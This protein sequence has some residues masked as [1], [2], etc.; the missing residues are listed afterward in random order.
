[1]NSI[2]FIN[3]YLES[4]SGIIY[5]LLT[6]EAGNSGSF[7]SSIVKRVKLFKNV[8]VRKLSIIRTN[9]SVFSMQTVYINRQNMR[10]RRVQIY[11]ELQLLNYMCQNL[12]NY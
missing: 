3:I 10:V 11:Y 2:Y 4:D 5:Y 6:C 12:L 9:N 7:T 1:M 8:Y